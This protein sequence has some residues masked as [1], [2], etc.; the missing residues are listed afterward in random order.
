MSG[1]GHD[2]EPTVED[3]KRD[4]AAARQREA[5]TAEILRV[6]SETRTDIQPVFDT[7][8]K[9]AV[10]LCDGLFSGVYRFDGELIHH[11]AHYN[12]TPEALAEVQRKFPARPARDFGL[13]RAVIER[14]TIHIPDVEVDPEYRNHPLSRAVGMRSGL[15]VPMLQDGAPLG[16]IVVA[17]AEPGPFSD[18]EIELLQTFAD[19]AVIAIENTRLFEEVQA[20]TR[21]LQESL[22]FQMATSGVLDVIS[23]SP[24]DV[25]PVF[26]MIAQSAARLCNARHCNVFRFDGRLIYFTASYGLSPEAVEMMQ[27]RFP[28]PPERGFAAGRAIADNAVVQIQDIRFDSDY[29]RGDIANV[30]SVIAVPMRKDGRPIGAI[31]VTRME[32]GSFPERQIELLRTFAD[33]A[34]IAIENTRLF[35]EVQARTRDLTEALE[36]QTATADVL[37][38]ISRSALDLQSVL[39]ALVESAA[40]L[41]NAYDAAILQVDGNSLRLVAHHGQIPTGGPVGQFTRPLVRGLVMGRAVIDRRTTHVA[42]ILA[43]GDEYP[44]ARTDALQHGWRTVLTVPLVH[45][46]AAIGV[47]SIRRAEVRPF[48]ERQIELVNTFAD[49]AVIAIENTRL[50]EEVQARNTELRVALEQQTATS[51]L[52]KVI[53]RST[54]DIQPVFETL[55]ENAVRLCEAERSFIYRF[56]GQFLRV[57]A[58]H[59]ASAELRAFVEQN[60]I[61][62]G[63]GSA[64]ARAALER[65]TVQVL[66]AQVDPEYTYR[67]RDVDRFRTIMTV[68]ILRGDELLGANSGACLCHVVCGR[69]HCLCVRQGNRRV[70]A[71]CRSQYSQ[72]ERRARCHGGSSTDASQ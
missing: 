19:Q 34:V 9:S 30:R 20:R 37:K 28:V 14:A 68:P 3:L 59:N 41:C 54:F 60:P 22:E 8:V 32:T 38:V 13:G 65:R 67:S 69:R 58:T 33:Q 50:F 46:G 25:Q 7:I 17:R 29:Q 24:T 35:E 10:R 11:V 12:Y 45:A 1:A 21:E 51:E 27:S 53:G 4:L 36:Q 57:V 64:T 62:P 2:L 52:L 55:A 5:A 23:R 40:R 43:E 44:D 72:Y 47:I 61:A 49:Q 70:S 31:A 63:R 66:D 18:K 42:D 16:A 56:D 6:I 39:D 15:Y 26:D 71:C 48:T